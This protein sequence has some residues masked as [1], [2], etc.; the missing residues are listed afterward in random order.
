LRTQGRAPQNLKLLRRSSVSKPGVLKHGARVMRK[1]P[2][3]EICSQSLTAQKP[4]NV[5]YISSHVVY[6]QLGKDEPA[7]ILAS[8]YKP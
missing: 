8:G 7:A 1:N 5:I 2:I 3:V 6:S 4:L